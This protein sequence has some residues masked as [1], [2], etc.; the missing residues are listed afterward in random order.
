MCRSKDKEFVGDSFNDFAVA[1]A[2]IRQGLTASQMNKVRE[3]VFST[4]GLGGRKSANE[5]EIEVGDAVLK[6]QN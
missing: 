6:Q 5:L 2:G 3:I 1:L 4:E